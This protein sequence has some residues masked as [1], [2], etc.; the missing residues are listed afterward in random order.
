[1]ASEHAIR[2]YASLLA[3]GLAESIVYTPTGGTARTITAIIDR[4]APALELGVPA[5][6]LR[7]RVL[8][9]ATAGIEAEALNTQRDTLTFA[10]KAGGTAHVQATGQMVCSDADEIV[11]EVA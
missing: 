11:L 6:R 4:E 9:D 1:M 5:P 2:M 7:I 10:E 3:R 8:N